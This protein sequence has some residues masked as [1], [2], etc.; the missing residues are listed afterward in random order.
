M[1]L[2]VCLSSRQERE[3]LNYADEIKVQ[4]RDRAS[5]SDL[6]FDYPKA[7]IIL[8]TFNKEQID[9]NEVENWNI[10]ARGQFILCTGDPSTLIAAQ[11]HNIK[12]YLAWIVND[13]ETLKTLIDM[14][15]YYVRVGGPLFFDLD[16]VVLMGARIRA[17]PNIAFEDG[18]SREDGVIGTWIRPEDLDT[19]GSYID[20]IEFGDCDLRKEQALYRI[21]IKEKEWPGDLGMIITGL[22]YIGTNRMVHPSFAETRLSCRQRCASGGTCKHCYR[23][24]KLADPELLIEYSE[25]LN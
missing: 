13:Y 14:N 4:F 9:W 18:L 6:I 22:N 25:K 15:V 3:Y 2:K 8:E 1:T 10:L 11:K 12:A 23:T 17:V 7:T 16:R 19:Y 20:A 24:L 21:Y 5:I